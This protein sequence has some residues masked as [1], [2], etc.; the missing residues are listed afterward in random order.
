MSKRTP[1]PSEL[2]DRFIIRL[3]D[4]MRERIRLAADAAQRSM[5]A[6]ILATL[7]EAYPDPE[8]AAPDLM[9]IMDMLQAAQSPD[10]FATRARAANAQLEA[11][12]SPYRVDMVPP[13][14]GQIAFS[15]SPRVPVPP[16]GQ[17]VILGGRTV[18]KRDN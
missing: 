5:N 6:E 17:T 12:G 10:D 8:P 11:A 18:T 15:R 4:G 7:A 16:E 2:K 14:P 1:Y 9:E 13:Y 3:P